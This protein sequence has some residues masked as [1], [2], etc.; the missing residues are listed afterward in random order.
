VRRRRNLLVTAIVGLGLFA[1]WSGGASATVLRTPGGRV[2]GV[3]LRSSIRPAVAARLAPVHRARGTIGAADG[4]QYQGG[5]VLHSESPYLV[6][7][8]PNGDIPAHSQAVMERYLSDVA[9]DDGKATNVYSVL[10]QYT[11]LTGFAEYRQF[12][13]PSQAFVDTHPYPTVGNCPTTGA[14]FPTCLTDEQVT[15]EVTRLIGARHL[16]TGTGPRAPIY[17]VILPEN[18]NQ[19]FDLAGT[20]CSSNAFCAY[21]SFYTLGSGVP[22][23]YAL[24]PFFVFQF[25]PKGCQ[26]DGTAVYQTPHG[27]GDHGFQVSDN[28]SHELSE[29]IT[30]PTFGGY[31][32]NRVGNEV[33]DL[34]AI[35]GP[36]AIPAQDLNPLAYSP[37]LGGNRDAGTLFDQVINGDE[38]YN[39]TEWSNG[40]LN[41]RAATSPGAIKPTFSVAPTSAL[42]VHVDPGATTSTAGFSSSTWSFGDGSAPVFSRGAPAAVNHTY[43]HAGTFTITLTIVD[44]LGNEA[45]S[46]HTITVS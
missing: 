13:G 32:N 24:T 35:Y 30:D 9:A 38:Y 31:F 46:S 17:F 37:T 8:D 16:P 15:K 28:L 41:C 14:T 21:H 43:S 11:D 19:C 42:T 20:I 18:V 5:I 2:A 45:T 22:V 4:V 29:T 26:T 3:T 33:G 1:A 39:Q 23:L 7:W 10:R 34:C 44:P 12:F 27:N 6:F 40:D 25:G 36:T